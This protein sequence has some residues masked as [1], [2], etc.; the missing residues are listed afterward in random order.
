MQHKGFLRLLQQLPLPHLLSI[1]LKFVVSI[2]STEVISPIIFMAVGLYL[3]YSSA[4]I[5]EGSQEKGG[6]DKQSVYHLQ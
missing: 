2:L 4:V 1:V 5:L 3:F 6:L